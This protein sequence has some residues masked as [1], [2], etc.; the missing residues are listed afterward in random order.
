MDGGGI[1]VWKGLGGGFIDAIIRRV[2][3][4]ISIRLCFFSVK[5]RYIVINSNGKT[6]VIRYS[7]YFFGV[8]YALT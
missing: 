4:Y 6:P 3:A 2:S 5:C 1:D 8:V 7:L